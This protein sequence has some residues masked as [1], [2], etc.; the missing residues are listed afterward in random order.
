VAYTLRQVEYFIAAAE[1]GSITQAAERIS[2]SQPSISTAI[3]HLEAEFGVQLFVRH[4]AQGLSLTRAGRLLLREARLLVE[5]AEGLYQAASEVTEQLRGELVLGSLVTLAPIVLPELIRSFTAAYP[6]TRI[7]PIEAHQEALLEGL[8][9]A[10]IDLALT[11]DMQLPEG[12]EFLPLAALRPHALVAED[13]KL[14][15]R[16]EV[17]LAELAAEPLILLDLPISREYFLSLFLAEGLTPTI[18]GRYGSHEFVRAMVGRGFGYTLANVRPRAD[19]ALDGGR[20]RRIRLAGD[21]RPVVVGL[22]TL[23]RLRRPRLVEAFREHCRD[24]IGDTR[25]PGMAAG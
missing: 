3:A 20:V 15:T 5:Q 13:H 25:I 23:E 18:Q 24:A 16:A 19:R 17:S 10:E 2:I 7:R 4:H 21:P 1:T 22:A 8:R 6:Q 9:R 14:A 12:I 11:Y